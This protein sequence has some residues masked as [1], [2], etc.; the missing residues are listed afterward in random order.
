MYKNKATYRDITHFK[1]NLYFYCE[2]VKL[3]LFK[4]NL[5]N[6][7]LTDRGR[8]L[9][10]SSYLFKFIQNLRVKVRRNNRDS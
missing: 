2:Q 6:A 1:K 3:L 8:L 10:F 4:F 9:N 7:Y 5:K